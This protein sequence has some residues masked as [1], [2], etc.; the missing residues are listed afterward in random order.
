MGRPERLWQHQWVPS[1]TPAAWPP[2]QQVAS[3]MQQL[4]LGIGP[5]PIRAP[6]MQ[7]PPP[8]PHQQVRRCLQCCHHALPKH[9][10]LQ[11]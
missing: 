9:V 10:Q 6:V 7:P 3:Q 5:G 11:F 8:P 4:H 2:A 1:P